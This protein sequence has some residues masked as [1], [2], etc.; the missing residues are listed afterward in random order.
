MLRFRAGGSNLTSR[1]TPC[2]AVDVSRSAALSANATADDGAADVVEARLPTLLT[3]LLLLSSSSPANCR[4]FCCFFRSFFTSASLAATT[5]TCRYTLWFCRAAAQTLSLSTV[6]SRPSSLASS[7]SNRNLAAMKI[8]LPPDDSSSARLPQLPAP[9]PPPQRPAR[10]SRAAPGAALATSS[11]PYR[12]TSQAEPVQLPEALA[13]IGP[14]SSGAPLVW[15]QAA[16]ESQTSGK[17]ALLV[18]KAWRGFGLE[19]VL[20]Y[21]STCSWSSSPQNGLMR[22]VDAGISSPCSG[23]SS[24]RMLFTVV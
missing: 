7:A 5:C 6:R 14:P 9:P 2:S 24:D 15:V 16:V 13:A 21:A 4:C 3:L 22:G 18:L 20:R 1:T 8:T 12:I 23:N 19:D 17:L 10:R 11:Q